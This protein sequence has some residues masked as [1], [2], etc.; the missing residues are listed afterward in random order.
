ML[1]RYLIYILAVTMMVGMT[2][3]GNSAEEAT[4]AVE[5]E[6]V[7]LPGGGTN[8]VYVITKDKNDSYSTRIRYE[9]G[10]VIEEAGYVVK[11]GYHE[12]KAETQ[13]ELFEKAV[14]NKATAIL[15]AYTGTTQ[16]K[17]SIETANAAGI[18]VF[19]I[20]E[21]AEGTEG[22]TSVISVNP[23]KA[24]EEAAKALT[25]KT[26]GSGAYAMIGGVE[27]DRFTSGCKEGFQNGL[28]GTSAEITSTEYTGSSQKKAQ[29][30][31]AS[32]LSVSEDSSV[33]VNGILCVND[34]AALGAAKAV[35]EADME[36]KVWIVSVGGSNDIRDQIKK[37]G[38]L[39]SYV[40][41]VADAGKT[42]GE[43][44][45]AYLAKKEAG[46]N[47]TKEGFL[48]TAENAKQVKNYKLSEAKSK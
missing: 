15:C 9:A 6:T 27:E 16:I 36:E 45:A 12:E 44:A 19:L 8:T 33:A 4:T 43:Q 37:E 28:S 24:A 14:K 29:E 10:A 40:L 7:I 31:V 32:I 17:D 2:G 21:Q 39:A 11:T 22:A 35:K 25:D 48:M 23:E 41:P 30:A 5:E 3:C 46:E 47:Q 1:K 20:G 13:T 38:V 42:A 26:G 18:P 34:E